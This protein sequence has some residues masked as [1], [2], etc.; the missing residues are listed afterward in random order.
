MWLRLVSLSW[1]DMQPFSFHCTIR[2]SHATRRV[3]A[4]FLILSHLSCF[5]NVE[6]LLRKPLYSLFLT[7]FHFF[8]LHTHAVAFWLIALLTIHSSF[9]WEQF[10]KG[11]YIFFI[12][13]IFNSSNLY[14][15]IKI[16]DEYSKK[17]A[18]V[19]SSRNFDLE[20]EFNFFELS[21]INILGCHYRKGRSY[22]C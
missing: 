22:Q 1:G 5:W 2:E 17:P 12:Y 14:V 20:L 16:Y 21:A 7:S 9:E 13:R 8:L 18:S 10:R 6:L 19:K 15:V 4:M 11:K 3:A